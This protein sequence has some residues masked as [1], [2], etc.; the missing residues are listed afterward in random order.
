MAKTKVNKY[1]FIYTIYE[2]NNQLEM[3]K[4]RQFTNITQFGIGSNVPEVWFKF[5]C[6]QKHEAG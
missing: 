4:Q 1:I 2:I 6:V 5:K 3:F